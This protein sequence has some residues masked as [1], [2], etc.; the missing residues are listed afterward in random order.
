MPQVVVVGG[1]VIGASV[2]FH[3][4]SLGITDV[5]VLERGQLGQGST[6]RCA[7]GVRAQFSTAVNVKIGMR[8]KEMLRQF[9]DSTGVSPDFREIGYLFVATDQAQAD[10]FAANVAMQQR[11]GLRDVRLVSPAEARDLMPLLRVDDV[12][13]G[14]F[15]PSD[16]LAGPSE[17]THGYAQAARRLGV[18]IMEGTALESI[19][20]SGGRVTAVQAGGVRLS[21]DIVIN[22][23]GPWSH[24]VGALAGVDLP[25][26]PFRRHVFVTGPLDFVSRD[27]PMTVDLRTTFYLHPEGEGLLL[28]MSDPAEIEGFSQEVDWAFLDHLTEH[29]VERV[30]RL[31]EATIATGWAGLYEVTPD[32]QGI[33]GPTEVDGFWSACGFSGHGFMQAPAVGEVV[34]ALVAGREPLIDVSELSGSRFSRGQLVPEANVI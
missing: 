2:A 32:H 17:V 25:V 31:A 27:M 26:R 3:L 19:E 4:A 14:T 5:V 22:C 12:V 13:A 11:V 21:T 15:C 6:S 9:E 29:A 24:E 16:G 18:R 33:I 34:A 23:A 1:G 8:S 10:A 20:V 28:G 30:P 7:G